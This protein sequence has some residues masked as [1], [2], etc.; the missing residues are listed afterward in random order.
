MSTSNFNIKLKEYFN[1][2]HSNIFSL[3]KFHNEENNFNSRKK[4]DLR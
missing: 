3:K 4:K 1:I 2:F